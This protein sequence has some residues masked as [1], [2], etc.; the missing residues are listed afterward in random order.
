MK[1][2][3]GNKNVVLFGDLK[4]TK[5]FLDRG[6]IDELEA[7]LCVVCDALYVCVEK[8]SNKSSTL[9]AFTFSDSILVRWKDY[10][11]GIRICV[12]FAS[13]L[14]SKI[15]SLP[16]RIFVESG[17]AI[18]DYIPVFQQIF[19]NKRLINITPVSYAFWSVCVAESAHFPN[20]VFLGKELWESTKEN[21]SDKVFDASGFTYKQ[22]L[23]DVAATMNEGDA[24]LAK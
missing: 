1:K 19:H 2:S 4:G 13:D 8:Y 22:I 7:R 20:G 21:L 14:W 5:D 10:F 6:M 12:P 15:K 17:Y 23:F 11:E 9:E 18:K 24:V 16:Y 3:D